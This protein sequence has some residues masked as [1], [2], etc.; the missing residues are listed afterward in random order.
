M[1]KIYHK[2]GLIYN[3]KHLIWYAVHKKNWFDRLFAKANT[4]AICLVMNES[5]TFGDA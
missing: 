1:T 2:W 5:N 4:A 3:K